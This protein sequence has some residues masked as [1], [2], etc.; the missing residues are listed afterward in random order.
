MADECFLENRLAGSAEREVARQ[1]RVPV[2][3]KSERQDKFY[4]LG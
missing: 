2:A 4:A 1:H 3:L